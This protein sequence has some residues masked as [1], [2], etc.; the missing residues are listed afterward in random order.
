MRGVLDRLPAL[1]AFP[2]GEQ[3]L[4]LV[5]PFAGVPEVGLQFGHRLAGVTER[6]AALRDEVRHAVGVDRRVV[7]CHLGGPDLLVQ[8]PDSL[9][10]LRGGGPVLGQALGQVL[11]LLPARFGFRRQFVGP[12]AGGLG[13]AGVFLLLQQ[14]LLDAVVDLVDTVSERLDRG[15]ERGGVRGP[16]IEVEPAIHLVVQRPE[17]GGDLRSAV[18]DRL[19]QFGDALTLRLAL[20]LGLGDGRLQ[21][22]DVAGEVLDLRAPFLVVLDDLAGLL[23]GLDGGLP[24]RLEFPELPVDPLQFAP[25]RVQPLVEVLRL[26]ALDLALLLGQ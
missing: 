25:E 15:V 8:R 24:P 19:V 23:A 7:E 1:R 14:P 20:A 12:L 26:L 10:G 17:R 4:G 2:L 18:R 5:D 13:L 21:F 9:P 6:L 22:L 11:G 3:F 16:W